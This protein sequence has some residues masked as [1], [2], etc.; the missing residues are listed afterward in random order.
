MNGYAGILLAAGRGRRFDSTGA[1]DKLLQRL[2]SGEI[3]VGQAAI[4]IRAVLPVVIAVVNK[5]AAEVRT[6]LANLDCEA[7]VCL[8][9]DQGMGTSLAFAL[10][11]VQDAAGWVIG[12]ADMPYVKPETFHAVLEALRTG[13]D[14]A[15][16]VYGGRRGNPVGFSR[17]HLAD[18]QS[19]GGDQGARRLLQS[20]PVIEVAVEDPGI[21]RDIDTIDDL[22]NKPT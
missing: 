10:S 11:H 15:V 22:T 19:M 6:R 5:D 7:I 14:I 1:H 18:L 17:K 13:A 12:L 9:A 21:H 4:A 8:E 3:V 20:F 16:P 2:A